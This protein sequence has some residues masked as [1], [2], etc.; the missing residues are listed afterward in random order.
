MRWK[1]NI[2]AYG[3]IRFRV[4]WLVALG[5]QRAG[6]SMTCHKL[7]RTEA[8]GEPIENT[9]LT[10]MSPNF[11]A[12]SRLTQIHCGFRPLQP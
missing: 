9:Q 4:G 5:L 11:V 8:P 7:A 12:H 6:K 3:A 10:R 1:S 2:C